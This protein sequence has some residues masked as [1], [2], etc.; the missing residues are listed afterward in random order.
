MPQ[1]LQSVYKDKP[2]ESEMTQK[3][4]I[5]FGEKEEDLY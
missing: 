5:V 3:R 2:N 4:D 1:D